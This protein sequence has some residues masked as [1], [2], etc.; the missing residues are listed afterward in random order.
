MRH[1]KLPGVLRSFPLCC[2]M[3][4]AGCGDESP[5]IDFC[6][7]PTRV[8]YSPHEGNYDSFPDD[9]FTAPDPETLTGRR[10]AMVPG[11]DVVVSDSIA[12][13]ADTFHDLSTVDGFGTTSAV[14]LRVS[15]PLDASTLPAGGEMPVGIVT[16]L[17]GA[18]L[19]IYLLWR[20]R[21]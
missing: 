12:I 1:T 11:V 14:T 6:D 9:Y 5:R 2:T 15:G 18:P 16:A 4:A 8:L 21:R 7:G 10:V 19:F 17:V 20:S 3:L 13:W